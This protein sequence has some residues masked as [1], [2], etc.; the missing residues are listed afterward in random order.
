MPAEFLTHINCAA[1]NLYCF[2]SLIFMI[3]C[4]TAL[5]NYYREIIELFLPES[6]GV[7]LNNIKVCYILPNELIN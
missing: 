4:Y 1:I 3:I 2:R 5:E 7:Y 6:E